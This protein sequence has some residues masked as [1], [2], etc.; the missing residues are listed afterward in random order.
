MP[1][2]D[3]LQNLTIAESTKTSSYKWEE[4][5]KADDARHQFTH[6]SF[7]P[8]TD[9]AFEKKGHTYA[10]YKVRLNVVLLDENKQEISG[11]KASDYVIY[12]NAR[13]YQQI[14]KTN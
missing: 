1:I 14:I 4:E 6:I 8:L 3:Y 13:I 5:F 11:T 7:E 2:E 10:N 12:T 9:T